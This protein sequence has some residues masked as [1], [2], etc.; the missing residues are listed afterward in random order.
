[1]TRTRRTI[2]VAIAL[3]SGAACTRGDATAPSH[4]G[5]P[6]AL[7]FVN[8]NNQ[9]ALGG[10][11]LPQAITLRLV[12]AVGIGVPDIPIQFT[13]VAGEGA[14]ATASTVTSDQ[15]GIVTAPSWTLGK[16]AI[17]QQLIA[18]AGNIS[19][20]ATAVVM[21]QFHAEVRF[22]GA[23]IDPAY[24]PTFTRAVERLNAEVI[25]PLSPVTFTNQDIANT[26]GVTGAPPLSEQIG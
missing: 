6:S 9:S 1:M 8:G 13:V 12:D 26:C 11:L 3:F 25:G 22:F 5:A 16:L 23:A 17:P 18:R 14:L 24:L 19:A 2:R 21:T 15:T 4:P 20:T 7:V 10:A